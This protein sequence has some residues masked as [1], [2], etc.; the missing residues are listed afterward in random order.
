MAEQYASKMALIDALHTRY[1]RRFKLRRGVPRAVATILFEELRQAESGQPAS[2]RGYTLQEIH[3]R[4]PADRFGEFPTLRAVEDA[5]RDITAKMQM[6]RAE[7]ASEPADV[8]GAF[9]E[10]DLAGPT[11]ESRRD[12]DAERYRLAAAYRRVAAPVAVTAEE[13]PQRWVDRAD[14]VIAPAGERWIYA[15][16]A[17]F[18]YAFTP[19]HAEYLTDA[20]VGVLRSLARRGWLSLDPMSGRFSVVL[21]ELQNAEKLS[22][23]EEDSVV[24]TCAALFAVARYLHARGRVDWLPADELNVGH[25]AQRLKGLCDET[26]LGW[27]EGAFADPPY[28]PSTMNLLI[29]IAAMQDDVGAAEDE[30]RTL[31]G[32]ALVAAIEGEKD[33]FA[34][35]ITRYMARLEALDDDDRRAMDRFLPLLLRA[36]TTDELRT[37]EWIP[38]DSAFPDLGEEPF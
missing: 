22:E 27:D 32:L 29:R 18:A 33:L 21:S 13:P 11:A 19:A 35:T 38:A 30:L 14:R 36:A 6:F 17:T 8:G 1:V 10:V 31:A 25:A 2:P 9:F 20:D 15:R 24:G 4:I 3:D 12:V 37:V 26:M 7:V 34:D 5:I 16:L 28:P 23:D